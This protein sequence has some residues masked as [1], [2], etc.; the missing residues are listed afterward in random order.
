MHM[1]DFEFTRPKTLADAK[2][3]LSAEDAQI[4]AGGQTLLATMK[5]RLA[6]PSKLVSLTDID[7]LKGV[8]L[9]GS[10]LRVGATTPHAI[11]ARETA[12]TF[13]ALASLASRIGDPAVRN[14]GTIGGS[15]A[16]YDPAACYPC[17]VLATDAT[18]VTDRRRIPAGDFFDGLF[19][20]ALDDGEIIT[21][22]EFPVP[23]RASY[24]KFLQPASRFAMVGVFVARYPEKVSVAVTGVSENGVFRWKAAEEALSSEFSTNAL[25]RVS[26][27]T[28]AVLSDIHANPEYRTHLVS[29][30]TR[31]AVQEL[32]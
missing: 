29:V 26:L 9:D 4:L 3:A 14:R 5:Q 6:S 21:A 30:L 16:N 27:S 23:T 7:E 18:V 11:V 22:V 20:T 2:A 15:L 12:S 13:P 32:S 28:D 17:A 24:Q 31:R 10:V 1:Y 19:T 8:S 25:L